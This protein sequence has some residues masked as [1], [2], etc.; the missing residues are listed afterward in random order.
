MI[1]KV[2]II[3]KSVRNFMAWMTRNTNSSTDSD[4]SDFLRILLV[5][6]FN[7]IDNR[8]KW[9]FFCFFCHPILLYLQYGAKT[10]FNAEWCSLYYT[11]YFLHFTGGGLHSIFRTKEKQEVLNSKRHMHRSLKFF[12]RPFG[13]SDSFSEDED[14]RGTHKS[15]HF[16]VKLFELWWLQPSFSKQMNKT[17]IWVRRVLSLNWR[18]ISVGKFPWLQ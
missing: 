2:H 15:V 13:R 6:V 16:K 4:S 17:F 5:S 1:D 7:D 9:T 14:A 10:I 3:S 12:G 11:W 8:F 18:H